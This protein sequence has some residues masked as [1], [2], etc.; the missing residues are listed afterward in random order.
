M[1]MQAGNFGSLLEPGLREIFETTVNRPRPMLEMLYRVVPSDKYQER[2]QG[3]GASSLV[4]PFTGA[5]KYDTF[6]ASYET[7]LR[8]YELAQGLSVERR[9]FDDEQYG[10]IR[11]KAQAMADAFD[12][13]IEHDAVQTF[14]NAFTDTGNNR[15]GQSLSGADGVG[16]CSTAHPYSPAQ[17]GTPQSN[18]GTLALS[19]PNLDTTRQN[20]WNWTDD[21]GDLMAVTP[22][23]LLVPAE[24]ERTATQILSERAIFEPGS[25]QFDV[26]M[27]SGRMQ[28]VVWNRLTDAN[29][30]FVIDSQAMKRY[31]IWQWR[32]RPEF[33]NTSDFDSMQAKFRGYMRYG[34]GWYHWAW[35]FGQN[36][37]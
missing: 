36:P 1:T 9:L 11:D 12:K 26:N 35:I 31:L 22:D 25:A 37:S 20:M 29:A 2:Y 28:L 17:S 19:L 14:I 33:A 10:I 32:I 27:F 24:L 34:I 30:W 13:T 8:N 23:I 4:L 7:V 5:V 6:D 16:L 3:M 15:L 21:K 18:E